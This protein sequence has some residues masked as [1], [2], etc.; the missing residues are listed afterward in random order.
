MKFGKLPQWLYQA[1]KDGANQF[2]PF[3]EQVS[4]PNSTVHSQKLRAILYGIVGLKEVKEY[5][6]LDDKQHIDVVKVSK[7]KVD[8][9]A[10]VSMSVEDR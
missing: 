4:G 9:A 3:F 5:S 1:L 7:T 2:N 6:R 10:A 8:L